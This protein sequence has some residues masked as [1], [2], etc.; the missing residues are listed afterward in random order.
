MKNV[1]VLI[2]LCIANCGLSQTTVE[3]TV[4]VAALSHIDIDV[5]FVAKL[6]IV[7]R[8]EKVL[9]IKAVF[10]GE[11]QNELHVVTRQQEDK[12]S[13]GVAFSPLFEPFNDKLSAHK[14]VSVQ[15]LVSV[16]KDK[17]L[18][19]FG[20]TA[21]VKAAGS[22]SYFFVQ[23]H[24]GEVTLSDFYGEGKISTY[25]APITIQSSTKNIK[26]TVTHGSI[27]G[28]YKASESPSLTIKSYYGN[29]YLPVTK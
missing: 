7:S 6:H 21:V 9:K 28:N 8:P 23:L 10:E 29:I 15:L 19:V 26:A 3:H 25:T 24:D 2:M 12:L 14:V 20:D 16:P 17:I 18:S 27:I 5:N 11:Y 13:V 22:F 1:V 4:D